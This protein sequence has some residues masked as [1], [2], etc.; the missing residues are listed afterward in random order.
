LDLAVFALRL[1]VGALFV[2]HGAQKL[3]GAFGGH[4]LEGTA[5][6]FDNLGLQPAK[7]QAAAAGASE[8]GGGAL[9]AIGVVTPVAAAVLVAVMTAAIATVHAPK[10]PWATEGGWEYNA[11][12]IA[13]VLTVAA[14]GG[15]ALAPDRRRRGGAGAALGALVLGVAGGL[16]AVWAG[17]KLGDGGDDA[18]QGAPEPEP[19]AV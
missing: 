5:G 11:V 19:A 13:A 15:G 18:P 6:F 4:G 8:L 16:G 12:L 17:R 3:F 7:A 10:G 14:A 2:G 9:L 1:L